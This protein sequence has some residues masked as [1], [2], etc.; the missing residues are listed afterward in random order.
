[1]MSKSDPVW[2]YYVATTYGVAA[3]NSWATQPGLNQ[4]YSK[5]KW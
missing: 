4:Y 1:M 2:D 5:K 3:G